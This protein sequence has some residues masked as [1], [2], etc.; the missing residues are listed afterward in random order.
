[1]EI[2]NMPMPKYSN[3]PIIFDWVNFKGDTCFIGW[4]PIAS[5]KAKRPMVDVFYCA[6]QACNNNVLE[7]VQWD[8]SK[9]TP[10]KLGHNWLT[11]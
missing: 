4:N 8:K 6:T 7:T 2:D 1:M 10:S 5:V 3:I 11:N 9:F